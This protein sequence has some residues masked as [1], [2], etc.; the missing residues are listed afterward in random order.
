MKTYAEYLNCC[1]K[2]IFVYKNLQ[3]IYEKKLECFKLKY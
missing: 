2:Y 3:I 1:L